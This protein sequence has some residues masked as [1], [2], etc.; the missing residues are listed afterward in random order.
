MKF[1]IG[2]CYRHK[3]GEEMKII[4]AAQSSCYG[5][6]LVGESNRSPNFTPIGWDSDSFAENWIEISNEEWEKN[7]KT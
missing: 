2:K 4:G 6:T 7:F 3:S 5:I 1:E